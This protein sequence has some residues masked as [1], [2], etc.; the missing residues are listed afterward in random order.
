MA[1]SRMSKSRNSAGASSPSEY[2]PCP[3]GVHKRPCYCLPSGAGAEEYG[4]RANGWKRT[5]RGYRLARLRDLC[6]S[7][8]IDETEILRRNRD[9]DGYET[10]LAR[11]LGLH[12]AEAI[13]SPVP[14]CL[15]VGR[16]LQL[17]R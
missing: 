4:T 3:S 15:A 5:E 12:L 1:K 6:C 9:L 7:A 2:P 11:A 17:V 16:G 8:G 13:Q 10:A 14:T